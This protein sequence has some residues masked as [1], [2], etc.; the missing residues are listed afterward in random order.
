MAFI[1]EF[2]DFGVD[3]SI[4]VVSVLLRLLNHRRL[5]VSSIFGVL[6]LSFSLLRERVCGKFRVLL[7]L[8][9]SVFSVISLQLSSF[10]GSTFSIS[11]VELRF[12]SLPLL[13]VDVLANVVTVVIVVVFVADV[14]VDVVVVDVVGDEV[15]VGASFFT[16]NDVTSW[17]Y[18]RSN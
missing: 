8:E 12:L 11:A 15:E 6:S 7:V 17:P 16:S 1:E 4:L 9:F 14:D 5:G 18:D 2:R 13:F 3:L 10:V